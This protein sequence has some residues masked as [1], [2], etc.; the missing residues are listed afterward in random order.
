M[1]IDSLLML[2]SLK[3]TIV[4]IALISEGSGVVLA[5]TDVVGRGTRHDRGALLVSTRAGSIALEVSKLEM[6]AAA[7][8][9]FDLVTII[10]CIWLSLL[11]R[12]VYVI[13]YCR[14]I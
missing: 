1:P 14:H 10:L 13:L 12:L 4:G 2:D 5:A 8:L 6:R 11:R 9:H 7:R 3:T